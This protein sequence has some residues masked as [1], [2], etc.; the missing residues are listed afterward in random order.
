MIGSLYAGISGLKANTSAM[1]VISDNIANVDTTA[2]KASKVQFSNVFNAVLGQ[3][4]MQIGRGVSMSGV[5]SNWNSGTLETTNNVTDLAINGA[6]MFIVRDPNNSGEY[7]TR[8]GQFEF[9]NIGNLVNYDGLEVQG[10]AINPDGT[11]GAIGAISLPSQIS[12][13][14]ATDEIT[15]GINLDGSAAV[16]DTFDT[17]LSVYDSLGNP[18]EMTFNFTRTAGGWDYYISPSLGTATPAV[19]AQNSLVFD[20]DGVYDA[21]ASSPAAATHSIVLDGLAPAS[22]PMTISWIDLDTDVTGYASNST[23]ATQTQNGFPSGLLQS[24]SIDDDGYFSALF[25]NGTVSPFAQILLADFASYSGLSKQGSNLYL[26][27]LASGQAVQTTPNSAGVG[28]IA[29]SNLEMSNVDLATE[30]VELITTQRGFQAN[31][32]VITTS[33]EVLAELINL[34]R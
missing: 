13:P 32:K 21:A 7:Y 33:D 31:S 14:A 26:S 24:V 17:T 5:M 1:S 29:P 25:S 8:A 19:A 2:F 9:D 27:T 4:K 23:K 15:M 28:G 10:R 6:G 22:S 20:S 34:K 11:A 3:S 30:F 12:P 16:G 18:I